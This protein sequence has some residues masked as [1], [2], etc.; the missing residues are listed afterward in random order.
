MFNREC[1][2]T[3][4]PTYMTPELKIIAAPQIRVVR[5][6]IQILGTRQLKAAVFRAFRAIVEIAAQS[7][8]KVLC[9]VPGCSRLDHAGGIGDIGNHREI[10]IE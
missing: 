7:Q 1:V 2:E 10:G 8:F 5:R 4:V 3:E 9:H 6:G